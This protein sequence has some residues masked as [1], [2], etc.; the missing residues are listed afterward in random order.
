M[1]FINTLSAIP[2][3]NI[4]FSTYNEQ[5]GKKIIYKRKESTAAELQKQKNADLSSKVQ[6]QT[7]KLN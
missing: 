2:K 5:S 3:Q 4:F 7:G 6:K 1:L